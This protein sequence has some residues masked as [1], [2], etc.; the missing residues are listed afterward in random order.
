MFGFRHQRVSHN[1]VS[2]NMFLTTM[3]KLQVIILFIIFLVAISATSISA[4][5][6]Q[7]RTGSARAAYGKPVEE[8][9]T[10]KKAKKRAKKT[11]K[12]KERKSSNKNAAP[13]YRKRDP[14]VS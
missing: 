7:E 9:P 5:R 3:R 6:R 4:Q 14:W 1:G 11:K 12:K 8:F 2:V 10:K 13:R